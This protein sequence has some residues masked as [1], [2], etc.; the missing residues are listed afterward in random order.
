MGVPALTAVGL[1]GAMLVALPA[2]A[3]AAPGTLEVEHTL[4]TSRAT[5][6]EGAVSHL[7]VRR[8]TRLLV[9]RAAQALAYTVRRH[10]RP[11]RLTVASFQRPCAGNCDRLDPPADRCSRSVRVFSG[12]T[13]RVRITT[14]PFRGCRIRVR[15]EPAFPPPGRIEAVK[16]YLPGRAASSFAL[17]D[18]HGRAHGLRPRRRY[19]SASVV[20]AMVLVA[21][22][23]R[24]GDRLPDPAERAVLGPMITRSHNRRATTAYGWVGDAGLLDVAGAVGMRDLV[25]AGHWSGTSISAADQA[26]FFLR[27]D[28]LVPPASR[29]YAR[30]LLSSIV[31]RQRWG[32]SRISLSAGWHTLFKGGWRRSASGRLVHEAAQFEREGVRFSLAVLT[33]ANPSHDYGTATLRGVAR[34]MFGPPGPPAP[35]AIMGP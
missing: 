15:Y 19:V 5:Y 3:G 2:T 21:Y 16:A 20:K 28:S 23:R 25:V 22:L 17:I 32:F 26:R 7:R 1:V 11:G 31:E 9:R 30:R 18:S 33:D 12:E 29:G 4:D 35:V 8:G 24:I 10:P 34:L 14:R 13:T 6:V 27:L